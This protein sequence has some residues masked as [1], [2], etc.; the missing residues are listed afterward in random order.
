MAKLIEILARNLK[1]WPMACGAQHYARAMAQDSTGFT[2]RLDHL[3]SADPGQFYAGF[4]SRAEWTGGGIS[5][6]LADDHATAI[7]TRAE[8]QAAVDALKAKDHQDATTWM[9]D[10][11]WLKPL[12]R[13]SIRSEVAACTDKAP[14]WNGEGLPPVGALIEASF[15]CEDFEIW[16]DGVCVAV[17]EDPEG[18]E[19]FCVAQCGRKIAMY[20]DEGKRIRPRRTP[21]QI[22]AE[23]REKAIAEMT[24]GHSNEILNNWAEYVYDQLGYRK[25]EPK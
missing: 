3:A 25:Q 20:R 4:W 5:F 1:E 24:S 11:G 2:V 10:S 14:E 8:W 7:V 15:A 19:E 6:D 13:Y 21:E 16:H 23:E 9:L 12:A 22:A 18:R 17:G